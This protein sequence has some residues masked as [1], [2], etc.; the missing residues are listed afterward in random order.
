[1]EEREALN[2]RRSGVIIGYMRTQLWS[3]RYSNRYEEEGMAGLIDKRLNE[4]S[5]RETPVD[6]NTLNGYFGTT[7]KR[8]LTL[9]QFYHT[10]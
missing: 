9:N 5:H 2:P 8:Y 4:V 10:E 6:K 7:P 1:M 3:R